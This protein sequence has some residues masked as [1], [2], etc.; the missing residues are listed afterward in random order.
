MRIDE[1]KHLRNSL[2]DIIQKNESKGV[3]MPSCITDL[4]DFLQL[5]DV[6]DFEDIVGDDP[7][8]P[9]WKFVLD[10]G[11]DHLPGVREA[12]EEFEAEIKGFRS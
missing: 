11:F 5:L 9:C 4:R 6:P 8:V 2:L 1:L 10:G 12:F 3:A 7:D